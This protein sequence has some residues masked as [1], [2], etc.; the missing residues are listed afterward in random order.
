MR[1]P[2]LVYKATSDEADGKITA[3]W[4]KSDGSV[5]GDPLTLKVLP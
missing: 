4:V 1:A 3:K 5:T 2:L